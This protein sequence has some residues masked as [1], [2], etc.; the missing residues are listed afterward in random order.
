MKV[1]SGSYNPYHYTDE[2]G[3]SSSTSYDAKPTVTIAPDGSYSGWL[4]IKSKGLDTFRP[5]A[6]LISNT[7]CFNHT[8]SMFS[9]PALD[10]T[11]TGGVLMDSNGST[12]TAFGNVVLAYNE[13]SDL[14][15]STIAEDNGYPD[16][17]GVLHNLG[18]WLYHGCLRSLR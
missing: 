9:V 13:S 16:D 12:N 8:V 3:W 5:R 15:G 2:F 14:I 11:T 17:T 1:Y 10:L 4:F 6:R 18:R 7:S